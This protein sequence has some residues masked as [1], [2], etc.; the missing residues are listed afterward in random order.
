[1]REILVQL[2]TFLRGAGSG[3]PSTASTCGLQRI[4][5]PARRHHLSAEVRALHPGDP[6]PGH[7]GDFA[8][9]P[10]LRPRNE[11]RLSAYGV[12]E[13]WL[14]VADERSCLY[15]R[16]GERSCRSSQRASAASSIIAGFDWS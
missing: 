3:T 7:R 10:P 12:Q 16:E 9:F 4:C 8:R 2:A 14:V 5:L 11:A 13:Y 15:R 1:M 6:R